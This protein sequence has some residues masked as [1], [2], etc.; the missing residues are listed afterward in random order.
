MDRTCAVA[1]FFAVALAGDIASGVADEAVEIVIDAD[2]VQGELYN[3]WNVHPCTVQAPFKDESKHEELRRK[4][5]YAKYINCVRFLGGKKLEKDDYFRGVDEN[6]ETVC[7]FTEGIALLAGIIKCGYTPWIVL[8]NVP[9]G[10]CSE[11][12]QNRYGNTE[13][14]DDFAVWSSYVRQLV[15]ALIDEFGR[16]QVRRW[17]FRVGTEPDLRPGH[18][19]G[20]KEEYLQHYDH[21]VAAVLGVLGEAEIGPGNIV[22]PAKKRKWE[23][24]GRDIIDHCGAGTNYATG[25]T[26][27]SMKFFASSYYTD[28]GS[29]DERFDETIGLMRERLAQHP[30]FSDVPVEVHEFGV[31]SEGGKWIVGDHS[32]WGGSWM[33]HMAGKIYSL[34]VPR[35]YQWTWNTTQ[36]GIRTPV[37]HVMGM[38]EE[39]GGGKRLSTR[40]SRRSELDDIGCIASRD[41]ARINLLI[42]RHLYTRDGGE[43]VTV[44]VVLEGESLAGRKWRVTRGHII[45][46]EHPGHIYEQKADMDKARAE[47]GEDANPYAVAVGIMMANR[48]KYIEMSRLSELE[49]L[50]DLSVD[51]S[52]R[53][54]FELELEGHSVINL[55]LE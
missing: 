14:P 5:P 20:T 31:L 2:A 28:V 36:G 19:S 41:D 13:P 6:G 54:Y 9:A 49:E 55:R 17:R 37:T 12:A 53:I 48:D 15:Q 7:D 46:R 50:P 34:G 25:R 39:M 42:Y 29:S 10:M 45:D 27:T 35:V 24:W 32:E 8:D 30:Q 4:Y 23:S 3:F 22:D 26:G 47:M 11:P 16:E 18:W 40:A 52:G 43:P 51:N 38:L 21:T 33:A 1:L 44:G